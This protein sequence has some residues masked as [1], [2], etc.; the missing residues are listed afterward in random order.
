[1]FWVI[2]IGAQR[3]QPFRN[4]PK[5]CSLHAAYK[6][7]ISSDKH[8]FRFRHLD[9]MCFDTHFMGFDTDIIIF[10]I[11]IFKSR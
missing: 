4:I 1:M 9:N 2:N 6:S 8:R 5:L 7:S 11:F 10:Q 3:M